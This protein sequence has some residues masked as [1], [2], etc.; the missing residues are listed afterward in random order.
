MPNVGDELHHFGWNACASCE[1]ECS[2]RYLV[3]PGLAS[4]R[5]H[6]VDT[7]NPREPKMHKVIEP[8]EILGKARLSTP[9]T[10]HCLSDGKIMISMLGDENGDAPGGFLLL[11]DKFDVLGRWEASRKR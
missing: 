8:K 10:V 6:I 1:G 5:I 9:H 3:I 11:N 7:A 2:R 4:G